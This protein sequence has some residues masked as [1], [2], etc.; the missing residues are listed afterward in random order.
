MADKIPGKS[1]EIPVKEHAQ[2]TLKVQDLVKT[3]NSIMNPD[4]P[5][6][7][8]F[9]G[10]EDGQAAIEVRDGETAIVNQNALMSCDVDG[11]HI[12]NL[13]VVGYDGRDGGVYCDGEDTDVL[14]ENAYISLEGEG[15]GLG[16]PDT[17]VSARNK[18]TVTI[19][20]AVM[21]CYGKSRFCTTAETGS[22]LYVYDSVLWSHGQPWGE[23]YKPI[24]EPMATPPASLLIEGN[25]RTHC[26][27]TNSSSYFYDS[28]IICDGWGALSTE[29]AE[30]FVYLEANDCD[31]IVTRRGYG[32]YAD[33]DCHVYFNGCN[34]DVADMSVILAGKADAHFAE[35]VCEN[36]TYFALVHNVNGQP[37][38]TGSL[39]ARNCNIRSR[40]ELVLCRSENLDLYFE[41]SELYSETG[42]ILRSELN[43]DPAHTIPSDHPYGIHA[44]FEEMKLEGDVIHEDPERPMFLDL[45]KVHMTGAVKGANVSMDA[46]S[47]WY[48]PADSE[49]TFISDIFLNQIDAPEGVV[50]RACAGRPG[51]FT[52]HS[53]GTLIVAP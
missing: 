18:A 44:V 39:E 49:V 5:V 6:F 11:Q 14:I 35:C 20:N 43:D 27:M 17:G 36:G 7:D 16:G 21:N 37:E 25:S 8:W 9:A 13:K 23:G 47:F 26:T 19:K 31:V 48:A 41:K 28:K 22:R 3:V 50:I 52:L 33:P 45:R 30:G 4:G 34:F 38:E 24:T 29:G 12:C 53:G 51:E 46:E 10:Y 1:I 15:K 32:A 40:K 42:V 2:I